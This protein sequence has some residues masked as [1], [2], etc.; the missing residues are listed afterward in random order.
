MKSWA[1]FA[2]CKR[3]TYAWLPSIPGHWDAAR[4]RRFARI[5]TGGTP[6]R[7]V[8]EFWRDGTIP[9]LSSGEVNKGVIR[10]VDGRITEAGM[11]SSNAKL[12]PAGSV[13]IAMNGQ[14]RTKGTAALLA[15]PA[16]CNQSIAAAICDSRR[17]EPRYL[18]YYAVAKYSEIRGL[19]GEQ[20][21]GLSLADIADIPVPVPPLAEQRTIADFLDRETAKIDTLIAA[22]RRIL[23]AI[24]EAV[25]TEVAEVFAALD[26]PRVPL[27]RICSRVDVGIAE[28]ATHAYSLS[29]IALVRSTN[30]R[31]NRIDLEHLLYIDPAFASGRASKRLRVGDILTVRT[32]NAGVSAIVPPELDGAQCF[33][34]LIASLKPCHVP[35]F[36]CR[37]LNSRIARS[38]FEV[39]GFGTA[40]VNIS[41]PILQQL[42]VPLLER[43]AQLAAVETLSAALNK[44]TVVRLAVDK[45]RKKLIEY[46]SALITAAVTGQIDV[47]SYKS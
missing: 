3:T 2:S 8:A 41:V 30:V 29:G 11:R 9:W 10:E 35:E 14:G 7:E 5:E 1:S 24:E 17:L 20:R 21:D 13:V 25:D 46:R 15:V 22:K 12:L 18:H 16:T 40:Q 36:Y 33:T 39:E 42:P 27:K 45:A 37:Y 44:R 34:L 38:Y 23:R 26:A 31:A 28:A 4:L 32:G 19:A 6:S 43:N 47:R